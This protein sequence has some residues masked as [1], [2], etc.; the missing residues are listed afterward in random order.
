MKVTLITFSKS[1]DPSEII[2]I[3]IFAAQE[4]F[5]LLNKHHLLYTFKEQ[6]FFEIEMF[7]KM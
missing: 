6:H 2:L 5:I 7:S 3:W 1:R 4:T